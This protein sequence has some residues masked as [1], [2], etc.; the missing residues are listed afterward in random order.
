MSEERIF[1]LEN[2]VHDLTQAVQELNRRLS[3]LEGSPSPQPVKID[4]VEPTGEPV[5]ASG[6]SLSASR[7][8]LLLGRS[9]L[10]LAGG[11]LLR[12][13]TEGGSIPPLAGFTLGMVYSL[14][15]IFLAYRILK[16][17]DHLGAG[18]IG[19]TAAMVAYPF[20]TESITK[21]NLIAEVPGGLALALVTAA[22][23][24][25]AWIRRQRFL[26]W[27]YCLA[28]LVTV[29]VL[30]FSSG[31]PAFYALLLLLLGAV[32]TLLAY[33]RRWHLK[34][35][36]VGIAANI[37]FFRLTVVATNPAG[38]G[39][40]D[41]AVSSGEMLALDLGLL[42][43]YL[44]FF[45]Y[46]A[47]VQGK[48]VRVFDVVQSG[49]VLAVGFGGATRIAETTGHGV[50]AL[51]WTALAAAMAF[52]TIAFTAVRSRLGR[53][54]GFFYFASLALIFLV[55]GS[56]AIAQGP[57]LAWIWLALGLVMTILGSRF[58]RVTLR[59]HSVIYVALASIQTGL[60]SAAI[61]T[62]AGAPDA[63][64]RS[65]NG[66]GIVTVVVA[67]ACYVIFVM[68]AGHENDK[69]TRRT[70]DVLA[71]VL[72]LLGLGYLTITLVTRMVTDV[73]PAADPAVIAVTR[74]AVLSITAVALAL[75]CRK[76]R[77]RELSWLVYPLLGLGCLKLLL[78]DLR[79]GSP[80]TLF[81]AFG[82]L[83]AA[84][85]L[86]P[87]LVNEGRKL[88]NTPG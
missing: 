6:P 37:V 70:P 46:R 61:D 17:V 29:L 21:L 47:L 26:A 22:G 31:S 41:T 5:G 20:L 72:S 19:M 56:Q 87:R 16:G 85:I 42:I 82:F 30:G 32:T 40:G 9:I 2:Q 11:F 67:V 51:G 57:W 64:W 12:A 53:G 25:T 36:I 23:L 8:M 43:V 50:V 65:L 83:G 73:P 69:T 76:P 38:V 1:R 88:G 58:D 14:G 35:W 28:S 49:F 59:Y 74:T 24:W 18:S 44:G 84:L 52:Y 63:T 62:F 86:A 4:P 10:V 45:C 75:I 79:Q 60:L 27:V 66:A 71:A 7:F 54:R 80:L 55:M 81:V 78:E 3:T 15:L 33:T 39:S 13:M 34:R 68:R 77:L 48:G